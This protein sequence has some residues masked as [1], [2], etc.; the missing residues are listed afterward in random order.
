MIGGGI[1]AILPAIINGTRIAL[2]EEE[3]EERGCRATARAKRMRHYDAED[4]P[5]YEHHV[6]GY[7]KKRP[8]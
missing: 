7:S 3:E 5:Q 2:E 4:E 6:F 1:I 8:R